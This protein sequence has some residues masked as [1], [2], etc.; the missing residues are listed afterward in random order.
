MIDGEG[1]GIPNGITLVTVREPV[2]GALDLSQ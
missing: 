1:A 2:D